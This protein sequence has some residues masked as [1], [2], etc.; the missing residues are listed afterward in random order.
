VSPKNNVALFC[1]LVGTLVKMDE[2]RQLPLGPN[3]QVEIE[4]MPRVR[5]TLA[6]IRD[7]LTF[8]VTNQADIKRGRLTMAQVESALR[9]VNSAL[10]GIVSDCR[11]CPHEAADVCACRKPRAG[12][13]TEL[14]TI[15]QIDLQRSTMVGDQVID[16][17]A[18]RNA[19]VGRFVYAHDFFGW[20]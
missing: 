20:D 8:V 3:G 17:E 11:V 4:L 1:D 5:E 15:Y 19:G 18:A 16:A 13:I 9:K 10:G 6:L 12:M 7:H 2:R 14:A